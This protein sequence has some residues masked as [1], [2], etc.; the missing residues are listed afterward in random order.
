MKLASLS[1]GELVARLRAGDATTQGVCDTYNEIMFRLRN[2]RA[3]LAEPG[4]YFTGETLHID[5][6]SCGEGFW[7][8]ADGSTVY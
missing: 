1:N 6:P 2:G 7:V 5:C 4:E 8:C 3:V